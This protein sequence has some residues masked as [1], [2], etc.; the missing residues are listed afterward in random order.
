MITQKRKLNA[1]KKA[2]AITDALPKVVRDN[3][4]N[5]S[6]AVIAN[7]SYAIQCPKRYFNMKLSYD[8]SGYSFYNTFISE[9]TKA[10]NEKYRPEYWKEVLKPAIYKKIL[11]LAVPYLSVALYQKKSFAEI[12]NS[13]N[14]TCGFSI[15]DA[16][17]VLV[18][19]NQFVDEV[20]K[21]LPKKERLAH[22]VH[23]FTEEIQS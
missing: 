8:S 22:F 5:L 2:K 1:E 6:N 21:I 4:S 3:R 19:I 14:K 13:Y 15:K 10:G 12:M 20:N 11:K 17:D 9:K 7:I 18:Y 16:N 23:E